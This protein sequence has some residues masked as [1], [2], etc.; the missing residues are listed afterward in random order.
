VGG[1]GADHGFIVHGSRGYRAA[2][3]IGHAALVDWWARGAGCALRQVA[4]GATILKYIS[5]LQY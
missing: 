5:R 1:R 2:R 3:G 4:R